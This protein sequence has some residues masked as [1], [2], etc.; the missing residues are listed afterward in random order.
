MYKCIQNGKSSEETKWKIEDGKKRNTTKNRKW[1]IF[2]T[3]RPF[4]VR[5]ILKIFIFL[6]VEVRF[7][8]FRGQ[9]INVQNL[10]YLYCNIVVPLEKLNLIFEFIL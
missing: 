9:N 10:P 4:K 3:A 2:T 7:L 1:V 5:F 6:P 8:N